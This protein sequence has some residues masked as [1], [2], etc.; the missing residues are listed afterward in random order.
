MAIKTWFLQK[1]GINGFYG[2]PLETVKE[3]AKAVLVAVT[4]ND[5][6]Y[7]Q[8]VPKSCIVDEWE[9]DTTGFGYHT[10][11]CDVYHKAY[12]EGIIHNHTIKSGRNVY[13]GDN[14][15]HQWTNKELAAALTKMNI[16]YM[17]RETWNNR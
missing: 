17:D 2:R 1:N 14:F 5:R 8:W 10:Y 3:T 13:R 7:E 16:P 15:I 4:I 6:R 11:L 9:K 12:D